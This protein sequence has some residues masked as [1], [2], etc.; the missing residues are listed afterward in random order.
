MIP[1]QSTDF[2]HAEKL[3]FENM[4]YNCTQYVETVI[5][6]HDFVFLGAF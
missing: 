3:I 2:C 4:P 5:K 6:T 1:N